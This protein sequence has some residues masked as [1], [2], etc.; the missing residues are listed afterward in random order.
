M[1]SSRFSVE[2]RVQ[3]GAELLIIQ[4][5][6]ILAVNQVHLTSGQQMSLQNASATEYRS[7]RRRG[8]TGFDMLSCPVP[9]PQGLEAAHPFPEIGTLRLRSGQASHGRSRFLH[10]AGSFAQANDLAPVGMTG[11]GDYFG[12]AEQAAEKV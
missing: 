2:Q 6:H 3:H 4:A 10:S 11:V 12:S 7:S 8:A 9:K 5:F 1:V